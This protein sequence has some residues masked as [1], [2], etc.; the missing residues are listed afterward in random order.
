MELAG[1]QG[2]GRKSVNSRAI[3]WRCRGTRT[4]CSHMGVKEKEGGQNHLSK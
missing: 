3:Q 4:R 1:G 2:K